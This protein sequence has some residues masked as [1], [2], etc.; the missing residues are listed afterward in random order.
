MVV[1]LLACYQ[2]DERMG[3]L[4][5]L[6]VVVLSFFKVKPSE[7]YLIR[8]VTSQEAPT[9]QTVH[10]GR[11][12]RDQSPELSLHHNLREDSSERNWQV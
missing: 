7:G 9:I 1:S 2:T 11:A 8:V 4:L 5:A 12:P 3:L 10:A 6:M